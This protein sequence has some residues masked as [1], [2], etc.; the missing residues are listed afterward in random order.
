MGITR[1]LPIVFSIILLGALGSFQ[2]ADAGIAPPPSVNWTPGDLTVEQNEVGGANVVYSVTA[3]NSSTGD[4][5]SPECGG[6][7]LTGGFFPLGTTTVT[8]T[9]PDPNGRGTSTHSFDVTVDPV[10]PTNEIVWTGEGG[11][12]SFFNDQNWRDA[13]FPHVHRTPNTDSDTIYIDDRCDD[14]FLPEF[15]VDNAEVHMDG[16]FN[17]LLDGTIVICSDDT[18]VIDDGNIL[19]NRSGDSIENDGTLIID[20]FL[21]NR[22]SGLINN[23]GEIIINNELRNFGTINNNEDGVVNNNSDLNNNGNGIIRN[24]GIVNNN[25]S[26]NNNDDSSILN[27]DGSEINNDDTIDNNDDGFIRNR[28]TINNEDTINNNDAGQINNNPKGIINNNVDGLIANENQF[29]NGGTINNEGNMDI[30][31]ELNNNDDGIINNDG[32]ISNNALFSIHNEGIINNGLEGV[33]ENDFGHIDNFF[34]ALILNEGVINNG[35]ETI[36]NEG[37]IINQ[38]TGEINGDEPNDIDEGMTFNRSCNG[39]L[40]SIAK[41]ADF[42]REVDPTTGMTISQVPI[43]IDSDDDIEKGNGLAVDPT[44]DTLWA[45]LEIDCEDCEG[46]QLVTIDPA[47]GLA[48]IIGDTGD[49]FAGI[50][51]DSA[52]NLFGVT[53]DGADVGE[54]LF[55]LSKTDG[56]A[57]E[58]C[59]L[60][61]GNDGEVIAFNFNDGQMY[62]GS[63]RLDINNLGDGGPIFETVNL[64]SCATQQIILSGDIEEEEEEFI[65]LTFG[66]DENVFFMADLDEILFSISANPGEVSEIGDLDHASKGLAFVPFSEEI[67]IVLPIPTGSSGSITIQDPNLGDIGTGEGHENG[68]CMNQNCINVDG[69]FNHFPEKIIAQGSTEAFTILV[70]CPRG[71]NTCNHIEI[72]GTLPDADFYD[73]RWAATVDRIQGTDNWDLTTTNP[74]EEIGE[75]SVTVQPI[76]NSFVSAT[77]NIPF[78]I[79][80]SVGTPDGIGD[81]QV[82]NRHLHVTVWDNKG[83]ISNYIFNDGVYVEDIYAYPQADTSFDAPLEYEELCLNEN[84]NKRYTCAFDKVKDWTIKNAEEKLKE[85]YA[86][87][88]Y[89]IDSEVN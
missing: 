64:G 82:N 29:D 78:L 28:G 23:D 27:N 56:S 6:F 70:N 25:D 35:G 1:I 8:C 32:T 4:L 49:N 85:I 33:I 80:G 42:L 2:D 55:T 16:A 41:F 17:V 50:A 30:F 44:T 72:A 21:N 54:T 79:S 40:Y 58:L 38:C 45:L 48:T 5:L 65:A 66:A 59:E 24:F 69:F 74:F 52:G 22:P 53:G 36:D 51:F 71:E 18:L 10:T 63:G 87:N 7:S 13:A 73:Y 31:G 3:R 62:H 26:I 81:P 46:R 14:P 60:G 89:N 20:G 77:F 12:N 61:N 43:T 88:N 11:D 57:T 75:V 84:S 47:T 67:T 76:G 37:T 83:G 39:S 34:D 9:V 15:Q 68:F 86:D 19:R